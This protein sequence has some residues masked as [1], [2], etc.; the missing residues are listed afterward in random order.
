MPNSLFSVPINNYL[1]MAWTLGCLAVWGYIYYW[2]YFCKYPF[3]RL[4]VTLNFVTKAVWAVSCDLV[5]F[6]Y[7]PMLILSHPVHIATSIFI[8]AMLT[9]RDARMM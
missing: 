6:V 2:I 4:D 1:T 5:C 9:Y 7:D 8:S 3:L